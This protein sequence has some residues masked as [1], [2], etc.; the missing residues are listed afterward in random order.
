MSREKG[1]HWERGVRGTSFWSAEV[2]VRVVLGTAAGHAFPG[3]SESAPP[4]YVSSQATQ[5]V[6]VRVDT[7]LRS[8]SIVGRSLATVSTAGNDWRLVSVI[9]G[10]QETYGVQYSTVRIITS[11]PCR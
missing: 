11:M 5:P 10:W 9:L 8:S 2:R 1:Y 7:E 3:C 6:A 4:S